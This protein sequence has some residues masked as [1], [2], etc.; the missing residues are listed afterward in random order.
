MPGHT[1]A[2]IAAYPE[3]GT[4][5]EKV[6]VKKIWGVHD[7]ILKPTDETFKFIED[8][9]TLRRIIK[10]MISKISHGNTIKSYDFIN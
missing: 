9:L 10:N 8:I 2:L 6:D 4:S 7:E 3:Y 5:S 1:S